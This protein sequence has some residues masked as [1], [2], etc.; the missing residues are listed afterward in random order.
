M[1]QV[2]LEHLGFRVKRARQV[3]EAVIDSAFGTPDFILIALDLSDDDKQK[4]EA[5]RARSPAST[6]P[7]VA[8]VARDAPDVQTADRLVGVNG[9]VR[10]P[11]DL[12]NLEAAFAQFTSSEPLAK[13]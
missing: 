11:F 10:K 2:V 12:S 13:S 1:A 6:I 7:I 4:L 5:I 8:I 9:Y 3:R